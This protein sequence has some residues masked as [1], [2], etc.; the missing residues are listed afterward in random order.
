MKKSILILTATNDFLWKFERENVKLLLSLGFTVHF[1]SN[2]K[3]PPYLS[4]NERIKELGVHPH[5]IDI[6]RSPYMF[7]QNK[8]ALTQILKLIKKFEIQIIHCHTPVGGLLGRL[9]GILYKEKQIFVIYTAHGFHFY[10]GA[11]F[12]NCFIYYYVEKFLA[13]FTDYLIVINKE[14][15]HNAKK[16]RLKRGGAIYYIP[17][18]G[19]D[20]ALFSPLTDYEKK[21]GRK[22]LHLNTTDFLMVSIG[23]LN[24]NKNQKI[25]LDALE[26][27]KNSGK[28]ISDIKYI[29]CGNGFYMGKLEAWIKEKGLKNYVYLYGYQRQIKSILGCADISI[30]P[31]IR[32][33]LGMA[34]LESLAMGVPVLASDNRGTRE[35]MRHKHNGYICQWWDTDAFVKG[36]E[37]FKTLPLE[38]RR[39]MGES[40]IKS[41]RCFD[42]SNVNDIMGGIYRHA[43]DRINGRN[44][45]SLGRL[46]WDI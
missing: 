42:K 26:K 22:K 11:P 18:V 44:H 9:A 2:M 36:I 10:R 40:C 30:F 41:V 21:E 16:F 14:D 27:M 33:G 7:R 17:G 29:I 5:H 35:Y 12:F 3:E 38:R 45:S 39:E 20:R 13:H 28:D 43:L 24:E 25:V 8:K 1:A 15:L 31:S 46:K 32:E 4:D 23:E 19:L 6:A 37:F 34:G